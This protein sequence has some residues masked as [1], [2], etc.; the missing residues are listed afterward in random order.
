V[1]NF[2]KLCYFFQLN[3]AGQE[4]QTDE[5]GL[6]EGYELLIP[7]LRDCEGEGL[8]DSGK[9]VVEMTDYVVQ[10]G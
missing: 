6:S 2:L 4:Q 7:T 9:D 1:T 5:T 8:I 10:A 3:S